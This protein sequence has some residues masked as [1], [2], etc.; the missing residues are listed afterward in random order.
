VRGAAHRPVD[1]AVLAPAAGH[2]R[3][4]DGPASSPG[5]SMFLLG[6][7][8]GVLFTLAALVAYAHR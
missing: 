2:R 6:F 3:G 8:C 5:G 7:M 4:E 1:L